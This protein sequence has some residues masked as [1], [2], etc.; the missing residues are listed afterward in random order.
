MRTWSILTPGGKAQP[1][2]GPKGDLV[3]LDLEAEGNYVAVRPSGTEPKVKFYMFAYEP[4]EMLANLQD[5][6][7]ELANR[8][9]RFESESFRLADA[10]A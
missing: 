4:P 6:K 2:D 7:E 8:L 5:T 9:A 10:I 1:L 3:I